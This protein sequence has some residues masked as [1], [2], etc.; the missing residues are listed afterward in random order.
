[1]TELG[2]VELPFIKCLRGLGWEYRTEAQLDE[3]DRTTDDPIVERLLLD[4]I[5]RINPAVKTDEQARKA[6]DLLRGMLSDPDPLAANRRTLDALRDGVSVILESGQTAV[7]VQFFEFDLDPQKQKRNTFIVTNQY[8]VKGSETCRADLV[9]LVN[10]IPLVLCEFKSYLSAGKDWKEGVRQLHR[11]MREAPKLLVPNV[12]CAAADEDD[13]RYGTIHFRPETEQIVRVQMDSWRPWLSLYPD[14]RGYWNLKDGDPRKLNDPVE[15]AARGLLRPQTILDFLEHFVVFETKEKK[16]V[17]KAARYQ[18]FEAANDIVDRTVKLIGDPGAASQD[19]TG[20]IWHTQGSGKSLTMIYAGTKLRRHPK[21]GSPTVLVVVDRSDLKTQLGDEF[22]DCDYPNVSKALGVA[23]LKAK[24]RGNARET[25]VTTVQCFQRMEDLEA[26]PRDNMILLID[27][28]HRSQKGADV[29]GTLDPKR[30]PSGFALTMRAKLPKAFRFGFTGTPIDR[31]M[32]NTHRM[33]GPEKDG[34]QERYLSYYGI[35][36]AIRD[37]ATLPVYYLLRVVPLV[38]DQQ[39]LDVGFEQ[40]CA[41]MEAEEEEVKDFVQKKEANW[42]QLAKNPDRMKKVIAHAVEHFLEHPDPNGFKAQLVAIDRDAAGRYKDLLDEELIRR[43][44]SKRDAAGFSDVIISEGFND[45][46]EHLTRHHYSK[47]QTDERIAFFKL[48][49]KEWEDWNRERH[50][51]DRDQWRPA[52][53]ILIVCDKL[54]TGF[55]APVEQVMYLD[56]PIRDHT[57]LQAMARTNRPCPDMGKLNGLIVDFFGVFQDMQKALNFDESEVEEAAIAW[58]KLKAQVP[59]ALKKCLEH[60]AGITLSDTKECLVAC[61]TRLK[62]EAAWKA[63]KDDFRH[64]ETLWEALAPDESLYPHRKEYAALCAVYVGCRRRKDRIEATFEEL[65]AKTRQLIRDN[66]TFN[67]VVASIPVYK[68][69]ADYLA[70]AR[71]LPTAEDRAAELE[72]A[73]T[74]E[75]IDNPGG[76][77]YKLLGERLQKLITDK[78]ADL[79]RSITDLEKLVDTFNELKGE[80]EKLGLTAPGDYALFTVIRGFVENADRGVQVKAAR[81]IAD[82]LRR[83]KALVPGWADSAGGRNRLRTALMSACWEPECESLKL[84]PEEGETPFLTAAMEELAKA[85][86]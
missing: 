28:C 76:F 49:P 73:L 34:K 74:R 37:G 11:Y 81:A 79:S 64:L 67:E 48:K 41:Q 27:E 29:S 55:D 46:D 30:D 42:K 47:E 84:C 52:L 40:M 57:L 12:F 60:V 6:V 26:N 82:R 36:Q 2:Y 71:E 35:R 16:T 66:A 44:M 5:R 8:S 70:K 86:P 77:A 43:G 22:V 62:D 15:A 20:L 69:D 23:D 58:D 39:K 45:T 4:A 59:D 24:L 21:L 19:R 61:R 75:L 3:Y 83:Q 25:I 85:G 10:G 38:V 54:L 72:D 9:L 14:V 80:A 17:K 1:M 56:K 32:V 65:G 33:F 7:T 50:G 31:T 13:F 51:G 63:F 68:I 18:Q 53:R 78:T